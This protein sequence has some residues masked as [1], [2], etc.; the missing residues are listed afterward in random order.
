MVALKAVKWQLEKSPNR[1]N[2]FSSSKDLKVVNFH[3]CISTNRIHFSNNNN[4]KCLMWVERERGGGREREG[5]VLSLHQCIIFIDHFLRTINQLRICLARPSNKLFQLYW[6]SNLFFSPSFCWKFLYSWGKSR[7]FSIIFND[8]LVH[9]ID[10]C[11][12]CF[13]LFFFFFISKLKPFS[14]P[15]LFFHPFFSYNFSFLFSQHLLSRQ[16]LW[17]CLHFYKLL[18]FLSLFLLFFFLLLLFFFLW[19]FFSFL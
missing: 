15:L 17:F 5:D 4:N 1:R 14:F 11:V 10:L 12:F 19:F 8:F 3:E 18:S 16:I 2:H 7:K 9:F 13:F 6:N